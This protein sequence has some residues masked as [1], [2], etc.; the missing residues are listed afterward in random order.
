MECMESY[1]KLLDELVE[2]AGSLEAA[3]LD[4]CGEVTDPQEALVGVKCS[5]PLNEVQR[6]LRG[7][8]V[9][10]MDTMDTYMITFQ[11]R[12]AIAGSDVFQEEDALVAL[13]KALL[14][15]VKSFVDRMDGAI[16]RC[17]TDYGF[18]D[19]KLKDFQRKAEIML[20]GYKLKIQEFISENWAEEQK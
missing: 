1:M 5:V 11:E 18:K 7:H 17:R 15:H 10:L 4:A 3:F 14:S 9:D 19:A 20:L 16:E 8:M 6:A 2:D 12:I 13:D